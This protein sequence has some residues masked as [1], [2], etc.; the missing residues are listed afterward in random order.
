MINYKIIVII[1]IAF[2]INLLFLKDVNAQQ[3]A[4]FTE[5]MYNTTVINPGY[6]GSR[7][8][9]S[10][11]I[12][13]RMQWVGLEG[14][15]KTQTLTVHSPIG[16]GDGL[17]NM[18]LGMS[19]VNDKIGPTQETYVDVDFSY[20]IKAL[21]GNVAFGFKGSGHL[22]DVDLSN[23]LSKDSD[24]PLLVSSNIEHK[25]LLNIGAGIYYTKEDK[26]Y[27]GISV[28]RLLENRHLNTVKKSIASERVNTY[29]IAGYVFSLS[30]SIKMKPAALLNMVAGAPLHADLSANFL[31]KDKLTMGAAYRWSAAYSGMLSYQFKKG[32]LFGIAYD[33]EIT[34]L[35]L[36]KYDKGSFEVFLRFELK[37]IS[38]RFF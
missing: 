12:L 17:K 23:L 3:D 33:K 2:S 14:A 20:S 6:A 22:L 4:H 16:N 28:P 21:K 32:L 26:F 18:G 7:G 29:L 36:T 31:I 35:G 37:K 13:G 24:D 15:P 9:F 8:V 11:G 5:Y 1:I 38:P 30:E 10:A 34:D 27:I 25:F 19:V